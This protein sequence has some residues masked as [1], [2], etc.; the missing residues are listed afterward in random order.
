MYII[1]IIIYT[2]SVP[3]QLN[4]FFISGSFLVVESFLKRE[5]INTFN[6]DL[7]SKLESPYY[8]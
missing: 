8:T 2:P 7:S 6:G 3:S 1:Y 4:R 5:K